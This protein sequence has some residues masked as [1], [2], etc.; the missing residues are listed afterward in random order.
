MA[1]FRHSRK[2]GNL[3]HKQILTMNYL[4]ITIQ[5]MVL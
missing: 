2:S 1:D 4:G 3:G 5:I